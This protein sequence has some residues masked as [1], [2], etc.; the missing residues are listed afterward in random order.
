MLEGYRCLISFRNHLL[1][2][3]FL[4]TYSL[5]IHSR[6]FS[7]LLPI[8]TLW[9]SIEFLAHIRACPQL[10][11]LIPVYLHALSHFLGPSLASLPK[12]I[13]KRS[14]NWVDHRLK[15]FIRILLLWTFSL[16]SNRHLLI[17]FQLE[18]NYLCLY[19]R[20]V[21]Y[22][23]GITMRIFKW[24]P[25]FRVDKESSIIPIWITLPRLPIQFFHCSALFPI[26]RLIGVPMRLD[27]AAA[28][29]KC[30]S[31]AKIQVKI[32]VLQSHPDKI[33]IQIGNKE[34]YW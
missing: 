9:V 20:M 22:F 14:K 12:D 8:Q 27:K 1:M 15:T 28:K 7:H 16:L 30:P 5:P 26:V 17:Q 19:S 6:L 4:S 29:L 13:I 10:N 32:D 24:M 21:W 2:P 25:Y 34:G 3:Y 23:R 18:A 33:W 11:S 31:V